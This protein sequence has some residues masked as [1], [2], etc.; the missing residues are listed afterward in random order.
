MSNDQ[1]SVWNKW[2]T[3]QGLDQNDIRIGTLIRQLVTVRERI[4][5]AR[6]RINEEEERKKGIEELKRGVCRRKSLRLSIHTLSPTYKI[7]VIN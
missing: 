7:F 1:L 4:E 6:I 3:S 5:H 2:A